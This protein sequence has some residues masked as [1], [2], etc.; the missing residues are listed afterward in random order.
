MFYLPPYSPE[1]SPDEWINRDLK[2]HLRQAAPLKYD[3]MLRTLAEQFMTK[4]VQSSQL[5][6]TYFEHTYTRY[7]SAGCG[8]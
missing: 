8:V 6:K 1:H 2:T 5:I 7:A 3:S 4:L